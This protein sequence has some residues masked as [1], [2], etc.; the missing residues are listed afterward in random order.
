MKKIIIAALSIL[1]GACG[2]TIVDKKIDDRVADL[3]ATASAYS[4]ELSV[5]NSK[6]YSLENRTFG[7]APSCLDPETYTY[8]VSV[9]EVSR[10]SANIKTTTKNRRTTT[11]ETTEEPTTVPET[12]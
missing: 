12:V 4:E 3:E 9:S 7:G 10:T 1:V 8:T 6:L 2:Y 11:T 5:V